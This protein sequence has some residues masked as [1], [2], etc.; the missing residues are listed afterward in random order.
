MKKKA[1]EVKI[2]YYAGKNEKSRQDA[3]KTAFEAFEL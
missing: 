3:N 1:K 2:D